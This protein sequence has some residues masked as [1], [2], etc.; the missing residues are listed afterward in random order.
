MG[1][2]SRALPRRYRPPQSGS[3]APR[4][5]PAPR[6]RRRSAEPVRED[7]PSYRRGQ[8]IWFSRW[9]AS[10]SRRASWPSRSTS[11]RRMSRSTTCT[12]VSL[13]RMS[14][15]MSADRPQRIGR[16]HRLVDHQSTPRRR[17]STRSPDTPRPPAD[18]ALAPAP[19]QRGQYSPPPSS[20]NSGKGRPQGGHPLDL[21]AQAILAAG[22][23]GPRRAGQDARISATV[24]SPSTGGIEI[25]YLLF[26]CSCRLVTA[27]SPDRKARIAASAARAPD[28]VVNTGTP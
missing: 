22:Q 25:P 28:N 4:P 2:S 14:N 12:L 13:G 23:S 7:R 18:P 9:R 8:R 27:I 24:I 6:P 26:Q 16:T 15:G 1:R 19:N 20:L 11:A 10:T 21:P 3:R 5:R 17:A